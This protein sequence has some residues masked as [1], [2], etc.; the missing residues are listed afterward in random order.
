MYP[1]NPQHPGENR[2]PPPLHGYQYPPTDL[3]KKRKR[4][5]WIVGGLALLCILGCVGFFTLVVGGTAKVATD[6]DKNQKGANATA[7]QLGKPTRVGSFQFTVTGM[8]CGATQVGGE[9]GQKAQ[10]AYCLVS[11]TV[12]NVANSPE[13]FADSAQHAIS[14]TGAQLDADSAADLYA[15]KDAQ[16]IFTNINPGNTVHAVLAFDVPKGTKLAAVVLH[17]NEFEQGV[18]VPLH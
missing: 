7:G 12:K 15:N 5:P 14:A 2:Q 10:G 9:Y 16:V 13:E 4:W 1:P 11:V 18:K 6:L 17:D 3:P 8:H